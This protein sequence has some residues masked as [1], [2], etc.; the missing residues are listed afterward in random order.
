MKQ[1]CL[2]ALKWFG[3]TVLLVACSA[4]VGTIL[5]VLVA[6]IPEEAMYD[7][8]VGAAEV[9]YE[10]GTYPEALTGI[11]GTRLDN[12]TDGL[13]I[14]T[15]YTRTG[16]LLED[17]LLGT[18][19]DRD[20]DNPMESL[21]HVLV[22]GEDDASLYTYGRYWHGY[23]VLLS[24][25]LVLMN[26]SSIRSLNMFCQLALMTLLMCLL[27]KK[28]R[29]ELCIPLF[30][31]WM[32][33]SP[34]ALFYSLQFSSVFYV[35]ILTCIVLVWKH[36]ELGTMGRCMVFALDGVLVAYFDLLTYPLVAV[37]AP[38]ILYF[39]MEATEEGSVKKSLFRLVAFSASWLAGYAGMWASKWLIASLLT[40]ENVLVEAAAQVEIRTSRSASWTDFTFFGVVQS[41]AEYLKSVGFLAAIAV[42]LVLFVVCAARQKR[43][44]R[45]LP[46]TLAMLLVCC[47]PF[48]WYFVLM[49]HS[50]VHCWFTYREL[51]ILVYGVAA[52]LFAQ[53]DFSQ[54][55]ALCTN[56]KPPD[57]D[58]GADIKK[59]GLN[60]PGKAPAAG[61]PAPAAR[62]PAHAK[63][64]EAAGDDAR[65]AA[66]AHASCAGPDGEG[67]TNRAGHARYGQGGSQ[68]LD[69]SLDG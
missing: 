31:M 22:D 5:L 40:G 48:V 35:S 43:N 54:R 45:S 69:G 65:R 9:L 55:R 67:R 21:Y 6:L 53:I 42:A 26:Y 66:P 58:D 30:L 3:R 60:A 63:R 23:M 16:N 29:K 68:S 37:G 28:N 4:V 7:H 15:A 51:A 46:A 64:V 61:T 62:T 14:N 38:L 52:V 2:T 36:D 8:A 10:E 57:E 33:L 49:N 34:I 56:E 20:E 24:P 59:E 12:Y 39:S 50:G 32:S 25:L 41:N 18:R 44:R 19:I 1:K 13:M 17:A 27:V 47:Y 11:D